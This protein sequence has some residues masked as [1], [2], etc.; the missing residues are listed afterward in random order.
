MV[1]MRGALSSLQG[2]LNRPDGTPTGKILAS[3]PRFKT[4][5]DVNANILAGARCA[6]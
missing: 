6:V 1:K 3:P 5:L 4:G 2:V